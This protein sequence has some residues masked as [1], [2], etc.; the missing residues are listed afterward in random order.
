MGIR[1]GGKLDVVCFLLDVVVE[2]VGHAL[3]WVGGNRID[4]GIDG[5]STARE[6][7][8]ACLHGGGFFFFF[9][10]QTFSYMFPFFSFQL[11]CVHYSLLSHGMALWLLRRSW[12]W[13]GVHTK[14]VERLA[15]SV[16]GW[17]WLTMAQAVKSIRECLQWTNS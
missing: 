1:K 3:K 7:L 14:C 5:P 9:L 11:L 13:D 10:S 8:A 15:L 6:K 2:V 12:W 16:L 17:R 4:D